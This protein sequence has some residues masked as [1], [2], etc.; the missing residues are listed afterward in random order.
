MEASGFRLSSNVDNWGRRL[1]KFLGAVHVLT[2]GL[3]VFRLLRPLRLPIPA[4]IAAS[5]IILWSNLVLTGQ[6]LSLFSA[7]NNVALFIGLS[8]FVGGCFVVGANWLAPHGLPILDTAP[9]NYPAPLIEKRLMAFFVA[10]AAAALVCNLIIAVTHLASNPDTVVYRF[11][12]VYWYLSQGSFAHFASGTDPR[13]VYYPTNGVMLYV[14]LVMYRFGAVWFN[15]P[16]LLTW[17]VLPA[18]TYAFARNLGA[19]RLWAAGAAWAIALTPNVL[20]QA[21]ASNDEILAAGGMLAGLFFLHRWVRGAHPM[22]FALGTMGV[23]LSIGTKLHVFFYWPYL[24][25]IAALLLANRRAT[26]SAMRTLLNG[27]CAAV[28]GFC[29]VVGGAM[30]ASFIIYNLRATGQVTEI[31]FA[32]QVLNTP[33]SLAV[34]VQTIVVYAAQMVLSPLP[35]ILPTAGYGGDRGLH[36]KSFNAICAPLFAWVNNS[37]AH[38]SVGYRFTGITSDVAFFLNEHTVMLGFSWLISAIAIAWLATHRSAA[39]A[40]ALWVGV[41]FPAWFLCWAGSTK[42]IE[43]IAVYIAYAA[44]ISSPAWAFAM[45]PIRSSAWSKARWVVLIFIGVTHVL[46]MATIFTL[47]TSRRVTGVLDGR[48]TLPRSVAFNVEPSVTEELK[49]ARAGITQHTIAWGQPNWIFMAFNPAIPQ[50]LQS[51]AVAYRGQS[52]PD[53]VERALALN[54]E[55]R[56]PRPGDPTLHVYSIRKVPAFGYAAIR[57]RDKSSPG[58]THIGSLN[59]ALGPE[60]VFAVGNGV[61]DR[62]PD[63]SGYIVLNFSE[64]SEFGHNPR[65]ILEMQPLLLGI[66]WEDDLAFRYVLTIDGKIADQTDWSK[67]FM[68]KLNTTGLT[69]TN[70]VLTIQVRN[71]KANG[72]VDSVDVKLRSSVAPELPK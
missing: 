34:S 50:R 49:H 40:W 7:L 14:P 9:T 32:R 63:Q 53:P 31:N 10:T 13:I 39:H 19:E 60:W 29:L 12:R 65:P 62:H 51:N 68:A 48:K 38:M 72:Q 28:L 21:T 43:G 22:D 61:E 59:F 11:P 37:P 55:I 3:I 36:Y 35:D 58:L 26:V 46:T 4:A 30:V 8:L 17:C 23:C 27:R 33:Y 67:S 69:A 20:I 18:T 24:M 64:V 6:I 71:N 44:I 57:V 56:M 66:G 41:S 5:M 52:D 2:L 42:Y 15:L 47:N 54:R 1:L 25:V 16:T 70:G 45:A